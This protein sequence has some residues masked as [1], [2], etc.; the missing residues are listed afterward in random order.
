MTSP[1]GGSGMG[2]EMLQVQEGHIC[3]LNRRRQQNRLSEGRKAAGRLPGLG[4]P[5]DHPLLG[6]G[7]RAAPALPWGPGEPDR[8]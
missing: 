8:T 7:G 6:E 4:T 5:S 2:R 1:P 3:L